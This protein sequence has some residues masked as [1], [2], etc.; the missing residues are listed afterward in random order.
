MPSMARIWRDEADGAVQMLT[1]IPAGEGFHPSLSV[2]RCG[3]PLARPVRSVFAGAEQSFGERIVVTDAR[4]T[5]G[6]GDAQ[7]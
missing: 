4:A 3:E 6:R 7:L 2:R 1:I 5:V